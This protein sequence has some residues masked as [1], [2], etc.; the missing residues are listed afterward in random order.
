MEQKMRNQSIDRLCVNDNILQVLRE[1]N[2]INLGKL[3]DKNKNELKS[4][5][6]LQSEVNKVEV[7]LQLMGL[8]LKNSL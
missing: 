2:I 1:N 6:L 4:I 3:C 5:G 8:N 7:K